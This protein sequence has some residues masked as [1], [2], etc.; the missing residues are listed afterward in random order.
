[1][2]L[3]KASRRFLVATTLLALWGCGR[4]RTAPDEIVVLVDATATDAPRSLDPRY[5]STN[6]DIKISRLIYAALVSEDQPSSEP[7]F[8]LAEK[9]ELVDPVTWD[10]T[11]R[12]G[13][14]FADGTP[15]TALDVY[16][17]FRS[18]M[19]EAASVHSTTQRAYQQR[20]AGMR[21]LPHPHG[22]K[23]RFQLK[24]PFATFV[25]DLDMGILP[26]E[27]IRQYGTDVP[28]EAM[29]GAGPYRLADVDDDAESIHL[30][31]NPYYVFGAPRARR[32]TFRTIRDDNSR[33]LALVGGSGDLMQGGLAPLLIHAVSRE[34][35]LA[36]TTSPSSLLTYLGFNNED[37]ILKNPKVRQAI[38]LAIDRE[39]IVRAK[40][41]GT[42]QLAT[43]LIPP[44]HWAY[45]KDVTRWPYDPARAK[46]LLDEAGYKDPDGDGPKSRFSLVYKT[47]A[48]RFRVT[49]ARAIAYQLEQVGISVDVRPLEFQTFMT[50]I[51]AGN[52]QLYT[53][54]SSEI[55]EPDMAYAYFHSSRIPTAGHRDLANRVRYTN[56]VLDKLLEAGR[57]TVGRDKRVGI[58]SKVQKIMADDL[59]MVP[60]WHAD[61][62]LV[63]RADVAG[64]D[65]FPNAR[66]AGL[67]RAY[68][69]R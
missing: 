29:A 59:P 14:H 6:L 50:D 30:E 1:M 3:S 5:T 7:K 9:V 25:T 16:E 35:Q 23:L 57:A 20:I 27:Q 18:T 66:F 42:A 31:A 38:A 67:A 10:I 8:D 52:F 22:L 41:R 49:L 68:K 15:V 12:E 34:K 43:G 55:I 62:I 13:A 51:R 65:V 46:R 48:N 36:V 24:E 60:L 17:T 32:V 39:G 56:H 53:L 4:R 61:N 58:Y 2:A 40:F 69:D 11:L 21:L 63:R 28:T 44:G 45:E 37:P 33:L 64:Y 26:A 54:Q 19:D 47:S